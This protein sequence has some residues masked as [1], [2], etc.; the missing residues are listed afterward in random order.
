VRNVR[1][2]RCANF[3]CADVLICRSLE[4]QDSWES[5]DPART[6]GS[7]LRNVVELGFGGFDLRHKK[8]S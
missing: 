5:S 1:K 3:R 6:G 4:T 8:M 7:G 2:S